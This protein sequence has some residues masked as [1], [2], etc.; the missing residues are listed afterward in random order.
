MVQVKPNFLIVGAAKS[1]TTSLYYWL[2]QHPE[3]FMPDNKEPSYFV[4]GYGI[5]DW[6]KYLSLFELGR[7]K[8]AIGEASA[9]YLVAPESAQWIRQKLGNVK[10]IILLRNPVERAYS[11]Y[12]W[13]VM[14]GYEWISNFEEALAAE[15]GRFCNEFFRT[16]NPEYF[17]DYM[18]VRSG[19]YYE[20]VMRYMDI[21]EDIKIYLF[22][23]LV[24]SSKA[25]Y[26]DV[27]NFLGINNTFDPVFV[28]QNPSRLPR[29]I[30]LQFI[31]RRLRSLV[32]KIP[33]F[34]KP[35][36]CSIS[37]IMNLNISFGSK[38][39]VSLETRQFLK[40]RYERD[41]LELSKLIGK[42]LYSWLR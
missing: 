11:L 26:F 19:L 5:S 2:K 4:Y 20:Q 6:E 30:R 17:W 35:L 24:T 37:L 16:N 9:S 32:G 3:V 10:I 25:I 28:H 23:E 21:F 41:I 33:K 34:S 15:E 29:S 38:P 42:D 22:D 31:L 27:C 13:M 40:K 1:G 12:S 39:V 18:Y 14:E 36:K 7:G 8:K